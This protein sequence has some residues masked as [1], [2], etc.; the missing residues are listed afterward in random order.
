MGP[1]GQTATSG[2]TEGSGLAPAGES[3]FSPL[4]PSPHPRP[5]E[6]GLVS[7]GPC[8]VAPSGSSGEAAA[9]SP[10]G[11]LP[12][13]LGLSPTALGRQEGGGPA[14]DARP[15][16]PLAFQVCFE[17]FP[18]VPKL[19]A[20]LKAL[21]AGDIEE[22]EER[23]EKREVRL[24]RAALLSQE[25]A[26]GPEDGAPQQKRALTEQPQGPQSKKVRAQ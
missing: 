26:G 5:G 22:M 11:F 7:L 23:R 25:R 16:F 12:H 1:S 14:P 18:T 24:A 8:S 19:I 3:V 9:P 2:V 10:E 17:D 20:P 4:C 13:G 21:F 6:A 15:C